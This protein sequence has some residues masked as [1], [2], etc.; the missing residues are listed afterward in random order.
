MSEYI[1][2]G[3]LIRA[4]SE[5]CSSWAHY[6]DA[7]FVAEK[8]PAAADVVEVKHGRWVHC[9]GKSTIWYCS[10]CGEKIMY[11]PTRKT[12]NIE[13]KPVHEV[14]KH[15]RNCGADMRGE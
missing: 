8:V 12:Y 7:I 9:N 14:N 5:N 11:N 1:E 3:A 2:R 10:E 6:V 4:L 15:C 13:K